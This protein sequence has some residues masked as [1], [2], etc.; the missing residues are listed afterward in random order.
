R[1]QRSRLPEGRAMVAA[2]STRRRLVVRT[3]SGSSRTTAHL[4]KRISAWLESVRIRGRFQ[5]GGD[6]IA[7]HAAR[8]RSDSGSRKMKPEMNHSKIGPVASR[9]EFSRDVRLHGLWLLRR[10]DRPRVFP[11]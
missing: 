11:V 7:L 5:L 9:W 4:R 2:E 10:G 6:G 8:Q 3:D 1:R